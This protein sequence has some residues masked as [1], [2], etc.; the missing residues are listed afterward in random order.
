MATATTPAHEG[1]SA[2]KTK[3]K[4]AA[5]FVPNEPTHKSG[6]NAKGMPDDTLGP[7]QVQR[8]AVEAL[9]SLRPQPSVA[10]ME[11]VF[12]KLAEL[13]EHHQPKHKYKTAKEAGEAAVGALP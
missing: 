3:H 11:A 2:P 1:P 4:L 7:K 13:D 10:E 9:L 5:D 6:R 12:D 8:A